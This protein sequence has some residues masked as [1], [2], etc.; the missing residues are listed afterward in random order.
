MNSQLMRSEIIKAYVGNKR[1]TKWE[2]KVMKMPDDQVLAIY[3]RLK[4]SGKIK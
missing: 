4:K 1:N 3:L 2:K